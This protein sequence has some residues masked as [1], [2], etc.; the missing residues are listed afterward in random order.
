MHCPKCGTQ[1]PDDA[2]VCS[3][4]NL[5]IPKSQGGTGKIIPKMSSLAIAAFVLGILGLFSC[6]LTAI[7]AIVLGIISFILIEKS[8]GKLTG[9]KFAVWGVVLPVVLSC[10]IVVPGILKMR[11]IAFQM[12]CATNLAEI[13]MSM[14]TYANDFDNKFPRSG[15]KDSVWMGR[16]LDWRAKNRFDAYGLADDGSGGQGSITSCFYL[17]IKY[18]YQPPQKAFVCRGDAGVTAFNPADEGVGGQELV[19]FWDF[20]SEPT[21]HCSYSYHMPFG[22]YV[23][24]KSSESGMAVVADRNPLQDSPAA[25]AKPWPGIYNPA[26]G[27]KAVKYG[28]AITHQ[29]DAQNVLFMDFHVGQEKRPFC[30][31]NDDNIYTS[32]DG[33]DIRIGAPPIIGRSGPQDRLD[34]LLVHDGP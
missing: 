11:K 2:Q 6:G 30:G 7:P 9:S 32:W 8:G 26:G 5:E 13:G 22:R 1:N 28:N 19:D 17:L 18:S 4:C 27:R 20:G 23:L 14:L 16:I 24:T 12:F 34:S 29:E 25:T 31:I 10:A 15:G 3:S 21:R 33:G